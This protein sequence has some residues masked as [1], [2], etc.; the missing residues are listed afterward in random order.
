MFSFLV[1]N[2]RIIK[3]AIFQPSGITLVYA[4]NGSGKST[5]LKSLVTVLSNRHSED[6]FRHGSDEYEVGIDVGG[7]KLT[8]C[9]KGSV[10]SVAFNDEEPRVKIGQGPMYAVEPRFPLKRYDFD[11]S[12]FYPNLSMQNSVPVFG[13]I[14]PSELF[15]LM[16]S[17]VA[18]VSGRVNDLKKECVSASKKIN[19]SQVMLDAYKARVSGAEKVVDGIKEQYPHLEDTYAGLKVL[20]ARRDVAVKF[21]ADFDALSSQCGDE[22]KRRMAVVFDSAVPLFPL[23]AVRDKIGG[24]VSRVQDLTVSLSGVRDSLNDVNDRFP[25]DVSGL[26]GGVGRMVSERGL[27]GKVITE[28]SALPDVSVGLVGGV[29]KVRQLINQLSQVSDELGNLDGD[30]DVVMGGLKAYPCDR[31]VNGLCPYGDKMGVL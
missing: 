29:G 22:G 3:E 19:D 20:A 16:F 5:L 11:G 24:V 25:V 14:D 1:K 4:Q 17:D 13:E 15:S 8:Y 12:T 7:S 23:L 6:N 18:K 21:R 2:Y 26:V 31:L 9:R 27:L 10:S 30:Y 28:M